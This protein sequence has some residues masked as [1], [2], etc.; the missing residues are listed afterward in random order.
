MASKN[1]IILEATINA[2]SAVNELNRA[3]EGGVDDIDKHV[4]RIQSIFNRKI[5]FSPAVR[6][7]VDANGFVKPV[8]YLKESGNLLQEIYRKQ[9]Q[10]NKVQLGSVTNLRQSVNYWKQQRD[11]AVR[12]TTTVNEYGKKVKGVNPDWAEANRKVQQLSKQLAIA[13]ASN[14]WQRIK[15]ELNLGP[16]IAAGGAINNL[17]NTFQSLSI[18]IGQIQA[19]IG[20]MSKAL[21]ELQQID[22]TFKGI[23]EGPASISKVFADSSSIAL[24]YGANLK[25]IREGFKQLTPVILASGGSMD[26]VS[27]IIDA[28]SSRFVTFGLSADA[29][30]RVMN[31]V[32]QAFGKGKLMAEELTQQISEADPAF[33]T[34]LANAIGVTVAELGEMVKAGEL[35]SEVL[36]EVLPLLAK[37]SDMFGKLGTSATSAVAALARGQATI[38][39]VQNQ[40]ETLSQLNLEAFAQLFKPLLGAFLQIQ[41]ATVDFVTQLRQLETVKFVINVINAIAQG[42]AGLYTAFLQ[43]IVV[44]LKVVEPVFALARALDQLKIPFTNIGIVS[45]TV[46]AIIGGQLAKSLYALAAST[47]PG[48]ITA[49]GGLV[50]SLLAAATAM[51]A[52][53]VAAV[54]SA[55]TGIVSYAAKTAVAVIGN[56][57]LTASYDRV[58]AAIARK[59]KAQAA[60][61]T[62]DAVQ[63]ALDL[64]GANAKLAG[65]T[66]G[67]AKEAF[68]F[69]EA[70]GI[71]GP[72]LAVTAAIAVGAALAFENYQAQTKAASDVSARLASDLGALEQK[73][74]NIGASAG[75]AKNDTEKFY[76][77]LERL[78]YVTRERN[79]FDILI[80]IY[81]QSDIDSEIA[82]YN[83]TRK[84][85]EE[86]KKLKTTTGNLKNEIRAYSKENDASGAAGER[87]VQSINK[88][89]EGYD[90]L[91]EN[92][93]R[94]REEAKKTALNTGGG[95]S[96]EEEKRLKDMQR[97]IQ[98]Y[99][100]QRDELIK[101]AQ[102]KKLEI[103][104]KIST[105]GGEEAISTVAGLKGEVA[106][107]EEKQA[108]LK[109]GSEG[110]EEV[111]AEIRGLKGFIEYL[112]SN[113]ATINLKA[114]FELDKSSLE[115]ALNIAQALFDNVKARVG[116]ES[117]IYDVYK[118]RDNYAIQAESDKLK[119]VEK[120]MQKELDVLKEQKASQ[121]VIKAKEEEI[122]AF[123]EAAENRIEGL[124]EKARQTEIAAAKAKYDSL[125]L[126]FKA[127]ERV[128]ELKQAQ[129]RTEADMAVLTA[130]NVKLEAEKAKILAL[131][132]KAKA[133]QTFWTQEDDKAAAAL[134]GN[135]EKYVANA[136]KG[137]QAAKNLRSSL[138]ESQAIE[139]ETLKLNQAATRNSEAAKLEALGINA[140]IDRGNTSQGAF[141]T[142]TGQGTT[143]AQGL[144]S[145]LGGYGETIGGATSSMGGLSSAIG[146]ATGQMGKMISS[147]KVAV[148]E[149]GNLYTVLSQD[150]TDP[151]ARGLTEVAGQLYNIE[152]NSA[153]ASSELANLSNGFV[154]ASGNLALIP[155]GFIA[156][157][158]QGLAE[159]EN[160]VARTAGIVGNAAAELPLKVI[161]GE[162]TSG[163][164]QVVKAQ[165]EQTGTTNPIQLMAELEMSGEGM[166]SSYVNDITEK[167]SRYAF[168]VDDVKASTDQLARAQ[169]QYNDALASGDPGNILTAA[170]YVKQTQD[171]LD[172]ANFNL[173]LQKEGFDSA[174]AAAAQLGINTSQIP[175]SIYGI[176]EG[177]RQLLEG[178]QQV[179]DKVNELSQAY[180]D[181]QIGVA[182]LSSAI[183][184]AAE[185]Q[186]A[187][188]TAAGGLSDAYG[189]ADTAAEGLLGTSGEIST[190]LSEADAGTFA[191]DLGT[192]STNLSEAAL[193]A[194]G[195]AGSGFD[196]AALDASTA[197]ENFSTSLGNASG[198]ADEI[199]STLS[200]IDGL[201]PTVTVNVVGTQG[202]FTGGPTDAGQVYRVNELGKEAFL[203]A[204]GRLSMINKPRNALWRAPSRGTVIPAHLTSRLDIPSGGVNLAPGA[205]SRVSRATSGVSGSANIAR[206]IAQALRASG[207]LETNGNVA[208]SQASQ[209]V[210]L[211]KLTHAVNKLTDKD[212]NVQVNVKSPGTSTY[213]DL[214]NRM[215]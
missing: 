152:R 45:G 30:K 199:Y 178:T 148:D 69:K 102:S 41:A 39:Q 195:V 81:F 161:Y 17:V 151:L 194:E 49:V 52:Q 107:L 157:G 54:G 112:E 132:N 2:Q 31:G 169:Q 58:S 127:E 141:N 183:Q 174:A 131:Q 133:E 6:F 168:A 105:E 93:I 137:V 159:W 24:K 180:P 63:L 70:I 53:F 213:M 209:A 158:K 179:T 7:D 103:V 36:L 59:A 193:S 78:K 64:G 155:G 171:A 138:Y 211:G 25:A 51:R 140:A 154:S 87:L 108:T 186:N 129:Q 12:L 145:T 189:T 204:S 96:P 5:T 153:T 74:A 172:A 181:T 97:G 71:S 76:Q 128:L 56:N 26:N 120:R 84:L 203:S 119:G 134:L 28:L 144:N 44:V 10:L 13:S 3:L 170:G 90:I 79:A 104:A 190:E 156:A 110:Y 101:E 88:Q 18:I 176:T 192:A 185:S 202:L 149:A 94:A 113:P 73:Y 29:S 125:D 77:E 198:Q 32:I 147:A 60:D 72:A 4:N 99:R 162:E 83:A 92:A 65:E 126:Q 165:I 109:I 160:A 136:E 164:Y 201:N 15:A 16:I 35:T 46:A 115:G 8:A 173:G 184:G 61:K 11:E 166:A 175:Q 167:F 116:L 66:A 91:I 142:S 191:T 135:A 106:K 42:L 89:I 85:D 206:A 139:K 210:Q 98:E 95:I 23:G 19:P 207:M 9:E 47:L 50:K 62:G 43:T 117:S 68:S 196:S 80:D 214:I 111:D 187:L 177:T 82:I 33:K 1:E 205:S 122:A 86:F 130:E 48:T 67:A 34:D 100:R 146:G 163:S 57:T 212:W 21:N 143:A 75:Q 20:A 182:E 123:K 197:G 55:I 208:V 124:R 200:N 14:F 118:A 121:E 22:L 215:S 38:E 37:N 150:P 114:Q 27:S 188:N 40:L